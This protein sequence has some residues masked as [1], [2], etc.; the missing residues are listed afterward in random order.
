MRDKRPQTFHVTRST[1]RRYTAEEWSKRCQET[2]PLRGQETAFEFNG[3][4]YN[5]CDVCTN[6]RIAFSWKDK[7]S[8]NSIT[9]SV[10]ES[11]EGWSYGVKCMLGTSGY[12]HGSTFVKKGDEDWYPTVD[13]AYAAAVKALCRQRDWAVKNA[14]V[15]RLSD[16]DDPDAAAI[17]E[18]I[19]PRLQ[20]A[21]DVINKLEAYV[22][23]P[24]L[25]GYL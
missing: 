23:Q 6:P 14:A 15:E 18:A 17:R 10:S 11:P 3:F 4:R 5:D 2:W 7:G 9:I 20:K 24:S 21:V 25:F 1:G 19:G 13:D 8:Y 12:S 22:N 16:D